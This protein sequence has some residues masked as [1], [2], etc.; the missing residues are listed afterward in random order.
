M[1]IEDYLLMCKPAANLRAT[2]FGWSGETAPGF[3]SRFA[4][5]FAPFKPT[6]ATTC[7]GMNDGGYSPMDD[8]KADRYRKSQAEIVHQM[9][10]AGVRLIV[11]GSPG[12]VD[13]ETFR[14]SPEMA[15]M[16]NKTLAAERDIAR[17]VATKEGVSY[18]DVYDPMIDV[19]QKAKAKYGKE[20]H[21][22]GGDGVHPDSNG[23]LVMAYAFLKAMGC[24]GNIGTITVDLGAGKCEATEGHKIDSAHGGVI[25]VESRRYPFCFFGDPKS[26]NSTRGILEFLPFNE[27]LNRFK[28]VATGISS[29]KAKVTWGKASK[30]FTREQLSAGINL[31]AE[32]L[33][34]PFAEEFQKVEAEIRKQQQF[35]TPLV[36]ELMHNVHHLKQAMPDEGASFDQ[37]LDHA[38]K[39]DK[40]LVEASAAAPKPVKHRISIEEIK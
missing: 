36:K 16:Y 1:F 31:A 39:K 10:A 15:V 27:E 7:Y 2:Q 9:K 22:A 17:E 25:D 3:L 33:D 37:I 12:C 20:Y 26:T 19:M 21:V 28:L 35:E 23:H 29:A 11:V 30:E 4:S 34:N 32:F 14:K 38:M 18:A 13:S 6:V 24:D 8:A 40:A 5:D